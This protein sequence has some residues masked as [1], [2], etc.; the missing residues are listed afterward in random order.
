M[1]KGI[2]KY[3]QEILPLI[4]TPIIFELGVHWAEDTRRIMSLCQSDP[5]YYGFEPDKRNIKRIKQEI[6]LNPL[7]Y[8]FNLVEKAISNFIGLD[9]MY[10]SD[11]IHL[12]S[13]NQMTGASSILKPE[14]VLDKHKWIKFQEK[15]SVEVITLDEF[16]SKNMIYH[17]DFIWSD[18]QGSESNMIDGA[19]NILKKTRYIFMEYSNLE[20]YKG[21]KNL[22]Q[23]FTMLNEIAHFR[24]VE[25]YNTDVLLKNMSYL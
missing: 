12:L 22:S 6:S 16:C 19:K 20:L 5:I 24:I 23:M 21:Q 7:K 2:Y 13:G 1:K 25:K 18:I 4:K 10:L 14:K 9:T 11:G 3:L 15:Q 17:I 8:K